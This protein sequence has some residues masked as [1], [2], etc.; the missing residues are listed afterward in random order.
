MIK[1]FLNDK[2]LILASNRGP[3]DFYNENGQI[4]S[5]M[6]SGG[7]VSTLKP[8]MEN[9]KG[10]WVAANV[11]PLNQKVSNQ[12]AANMVPVNETNP[13]FNVKFLNI[14][15]TEYNDYYNV[16]SNSVLWYLHHYIWKPPSDKDKTK[17]IQRAWNEG[18]VNV[19]RKFAENIVEQAEY[20]ENESGDESVVLLQDYHLYLAPEYIRSLK[21]DIFL[22][23]FIHVPW[24][25]SSYFSTLP[26]YMKESIL[27][28]LLA[29]DVV[30]FHIPKYVNNFLDSCEGFADSVD[31]ENSKIYQNGNETQIKSYPISIDTKGLNELSKD[32]EV[33]MYERLVQ[34]VKGDNFLIYRTDRAD[35]S[36]NIA[37]GFVA[38]EKFLRDHPE[39]HGKVTFLV[40]GTSTRE[41][42]K[43]YK[44]Y[45]EGIELLIERIN[46]L[47]SNHDWKPIV[48]VFNAPYE[49]VVAGLKNYDCLMVNSLCDGMNIVSKEGTFVN[50]REGSLIL[51]EQAGSYAE[52]K[53]FVLPVDPYDVSQTAE[54]IYNAV[55][56]EEKDRAQNSKCL[57]DIV[58]SN[59]INEWL[60]N[61]FKDIDSILST[62]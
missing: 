31:H 41:D 45:R 32:R 4:K 56:M 30:G 47:Y 34:K 62:H 58:E 52:L 3:I 40:T 5:K 39:Y 26:S 49:L 2:N 53:Q 50:K 37:R 38:Y 51:S 29:N 12:Y 13:N 21:S 9:L 24:P 61:Q 48:E 35:M 7:L 28:G 19:N 42:L 33:N 22:N 14:P 27:T 8:L 43:D 10:I 15:E 44:N 60:L 23:Q 25:D 59:T 54:A 36:K 18:Y 6:G 11:N 16:I 46:W 20:N 57:K 55:T 17:E 1:N